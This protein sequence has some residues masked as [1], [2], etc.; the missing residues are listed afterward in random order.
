MKNKKMIIIYIV[1]TVIIAFLL[2]LFLANKKKELVFNI[3]MDKKEIMIGESINI[4]Y[5]M[6]KDGI[7]IW[8]SDNNTVVKISNNKIVG[9]GIGSANIKGIVTTDDEKKEYDFTMSVYYGNK[10]ISI[11]DIIV[12]LGELFIS[13]GDSFEIPINYDPQDAYISSIEYLIGDNNIVSFD[14]MIH[15]N[16]IGSTS[17]SII[18]N[19]M[20]NKTFRVNVI[21]KKINPIFSMKLTGVNI[22]NDNITLSKGESKKIEYALIP[23]DGFI[24]NIEWTS[25]DENIAYVQDGLIT[26]KELGEADITLKINNSINRVIKVLVV[27]PITDIKLNTNQ[28]LIMKVGDQETI[29]TIITPSD[30]SNK[31][32]KYDN[33]NPSAINID[34]NGVINA[35]GVGEGT[36]TITPEVGNAKVEIKYTVNPKTGVVNGNGNIWGYTSTRDQI[37]ER[38]DKSFFE[39][40]SNNGMGTIKDD[41]Y[42]YI[43]GDKT[44]QYN[45]SSSL[46]NVNGRTVLMRMYY[47]KNVD[48]SSVNTFTFCNG[49]GD[50]KGFVGLFK[51]AEKD[52]SYI[53]SSGIIILVASK[54]GSSYYRDE[55]ILATEFVKLIVKQK[56]GVK[57]AIGAYS[58]SGG[59][60]GY[61]AEKSEYDRIVMFSSFFWPKSTPSLKNKEI[62][63]YSPEKDKLESLTTQT[64]NKMIETGFTNVTVISNNSNIINENNYKA[65]FLIINP[66]SQMGT[67]H[68]YANIPPSNAFSYACR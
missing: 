68:G 23:T 42:T 13:K 53:K 47:P 9:I 16:N 51:E 46:L 39:N 56:S 67:G 22:V 29:S 19:K 44:Y 17:I 34:S 10:D 6:N 38:A 35:I 63:V 64:L 33:S 45:L 27:N 55:I 60:V 52:R 40:L 11:N 66:A 49:T 61:A 37:P 25:S 24:E 21:D 1:F 57:N 58:G 14:G 15:A 20:I 5:E 43:N 30:A 4:E 32:L 65:N 31:N 59:E 8:E 3:K 62:I 50:Q 28:N 26:A 18:V 48:L 12:P 54:N 36:I 7:V 2:W 41:V